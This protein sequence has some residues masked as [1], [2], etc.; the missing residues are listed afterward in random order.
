MISRLFAFSYHHTSFKRE[1]LAGLSTFATMAYI[2]VVNA[3]ILNDGGMNF[4]AVLVA[5]IIVTAF[6]SALMGLLTNSMTGK[7][8]V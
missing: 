3:S 4:G 2:L 1:C 6:A 7:P 8:L 5:S